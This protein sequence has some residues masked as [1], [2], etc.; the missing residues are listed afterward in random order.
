[1]VKKNIEMRQP[2]KKCFMMVSI[3]LFTAAGLYIFA[4]QPTAVKE[5]KAPAEDAAIKNPVPAAP[6]PVSAGKETY[7]ENCSACH[8]A[9]GK[10]NGPAASAMN[11][12]PTNF[13]NSRLMNARTDG[14]LFWK[15][16]TGRPPMPGFSAILRPEQIWPLIDYIRT[17]SVTSKGSKKN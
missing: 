15:I 6:G 11:P 7:I 8:G 3:V 12:K 14:D 4:A 10:G 1:V 5:W 13:T 9:Q 2:M 16:N 17:F